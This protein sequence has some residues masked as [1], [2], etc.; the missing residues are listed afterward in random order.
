MLDTIGDRRSNLAKLD[1]EIDQHNNDDKE[2][3][4]L[5]VHD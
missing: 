4:M 1:D 5:S 2:H 3:G